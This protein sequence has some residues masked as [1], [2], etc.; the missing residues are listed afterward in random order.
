MRHIP[1]AII[2]LTTF[3]SAIFILFCGI[4]FRIN[5][6]IGQLTLFFSIA[7]GLFTAFLYW[8]NDMWAGHLSE[9]L[10]KKPYTDTAA[11]KL[12]DRNIKHIAPPI[13]RPTTTRKREPTPPPPSQ[14]T[15]SMYA[16][17]SNIF[18]GSNT[19]TV[20]QTVN[21]APQPRHLSQQQRAVLIN[22]LN[23]ISMNNISISY[24]EADR[25]QKQYAMELIDTLKAAGCN[26]EISS[27]LY[28]MT[29][30]EKGLTLEVNST[31]PYPHGAAIL[32]QALKDAHIPAEWV[33]TTGMARDKI[34]MVVGKQ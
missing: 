12:P 23:P 31:P 26:L 9:E 15:A 30:Y 28:M 32:Q 13:S 27:A 16:P 18:M 5:R 1:D 20:N 21:I 25:E 6:T 7:F 3:I 29:P 22:T 8:Q 34:W 33:G 14:Q 10:S 17:N 24:G 2:Y 19:G 11:Q 4:Y